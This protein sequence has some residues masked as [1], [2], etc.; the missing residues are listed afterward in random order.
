MISLSTRTKEAIKP[1]LGV[2]IA[3]GI[4]LGMG[5][6]N[7]YWAGFAVA[8]ISLSTAGQSLNKGTMRMLGTLAAAMAALTLFAWFAQDRWWFIGLL[9]IYIGFCTYMIAGNQHQYF[10]YCCAFIC[11]VI[12]VHS[13]DEIPNA[14]NIAVLRIQQ[15][16]M[17][18]LVYTLVTVF[19]WPA[20]TRGALDEVTHKLSTTQA[21]IFRTYHAL[22]SGHG[23]AEESRSL[24]MQEVQL[25]GQ[26]LQA[27]NAAETDS[28][29][30]WELRHQ[31]R[32]FHRLSQALMAA[33]EH[34]RESFTEIQPF[35]LGKIL[36]NLAAVS[37]E[38][39]DRFAE[40]ERMLTDETPTRAPK[41]INLEIDHKEILNH[42][43]FQKAAVA[44]TKTQLD[45]L[46]KLSWDLFDCVRDIKRND[47]QSQNTVPHDARAGGF[48][49]DPDRLQAALRAMAT[50]WASFLI[51]VYIDPPGHLAFVEFATIVAMGAAMVRLSPTTLFT[52]FIFLTLGAGVLYI[53]VMPHLSGY[54]HLGVMLFSAVFAVYY[55]FWQPRQGLAKSIGAA[56]LLNVIGVQNQQVYDFA[57]F[58]NTVVMIAL[59]CGIAVVIWYLPP[60]PRPEKAFLRLLARFYRHSEYLISRMDLD[61]EQRQSWTVRWKM[62]LYRN[63]LLELP[64][65][66]G[67]LGGQIDHRL[68][69][70]ATPEQ[71]QTLVNSLQALALRLKDLVDVRR[72]PQATL[73]VR[74]LLDDMRVWRLA[75][76]ELFQNWSE[77]PASEPDGDLQSRLAA[78]LKEMETR[79]SRT[80]SRAEQGEL[81]DEDYR[82]FYQLIGSYRGLSESIV[83]HTKLTGSFDWR[84]L[85]EARF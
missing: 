53:F 25:L 40:I 30:V 22:L 64:Q 15:T 13:A 16:G 60:S 37:S 59:A 51:W 1:A 42:T 45:R 10:W 27:L 9:S 62:A 39:D 32:H 20:R 68:F 56:M 33:L 24:R 78:K 31:W 48:G 41:P 77:D 76:E 46:E 36:P 83:E 80:L 12:G 2:V 57:G 26:F 44:V 4:S 3:Y 82:N 72:Y 58:A 35:D 74:E 17:G 71:V 34:W 18:I 29:E 66:L 75:I 19:L 65:K 79:I 43:Y 67:V 11:L 61:L 84:E 28:Y 49:L 73:L 70:G 63:D 69:P 5:W 54:T 23:T 7:P 81:S 47:R 55:V 8:M 50:L 6:E 52:P 85:K 38:I 14:F 21:T